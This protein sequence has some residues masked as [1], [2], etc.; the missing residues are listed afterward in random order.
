MRRE[1][2]KSVRVAAWERSNGQCEACTRKLFPGDIHYDHRIPDA[3]GGEPTL[4]NCDVL[5]RSCHGLKTTKAD[6][7]TIAKAKRIYAKH[8]GADKGR[9]K[10]A[11]SRDSKFRKKLNGTVE[12][13]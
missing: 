10:F 8:I 1:F 11:C 5:C 2:S 7:P 12:L 9:S 6:V 3:L 13:R 4:E